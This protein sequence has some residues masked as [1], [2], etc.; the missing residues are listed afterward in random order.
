MGIRVYDR[1]RIVQLLAY[2]SGASLEAAVK[3][4]ERLAGALP[5]AWLRT[6]PAARPIVDAF[7]RIALGL[8]SGARSKEGLPNAALAKRLARVLARCGET[9]SSSSL[10]SVFKL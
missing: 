1:H 3:R 4:S 6:A 5:A 7:T 9:E 2:V 8:K 10:S